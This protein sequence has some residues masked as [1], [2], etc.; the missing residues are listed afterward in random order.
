MLSISRVAE[1]QGDGLFALA[2]AYRGAHL[3]VS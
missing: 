1:R 3:A 2:A